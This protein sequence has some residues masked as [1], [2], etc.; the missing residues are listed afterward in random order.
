MYFAIDI[1]QTIAGGTDAFRLYINHHIQDLGLAISP[2]VV[3][4][5][6]DYRSFLHLP[7]V[8]AYRRANEARFQLSRTNSRVSPNIVLALQE[9]LGAVAGIRYIAEYGTI[10]YYTIRSPEIR[11]MTKQWLS[12]RKFP[13]PHNVTCCTDS[14][15]KLITLSSQTLPEETI[16]LIDDKGKDLVLAFEKLTESHPTVAQALQ[17]RLIIVA[18]GQKEAMTSCPIKLVSLPSW[19]SIASVMDAL[20]LSTDRR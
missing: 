11:E 16:V 12:A 19:Q 17:P 2:A 15:D 6:T 3:E 9:I 13:H 5:L 18:F 8:I 20:C 4:T 14:L 10:C 7:E 1:D